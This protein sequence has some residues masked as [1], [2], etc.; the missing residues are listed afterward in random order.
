LISLPLKV[1]AEIIR[2]LKK[3]AGIF[4]YGYPSFFE[5]SGCGKKMETEYSNCPGC[6]AVFEK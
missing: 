1:A 3:Q 2:L 4:M 5:C 6:G